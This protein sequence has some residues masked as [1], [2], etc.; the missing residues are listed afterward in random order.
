MKNRFNKG[1]EETKQNKVPKY[2]IR[3][4]KVG[5]VSCLLAFSMFAPAI[6]AQAEL[7]AARRVHVKIDEYKNKG[8]SDKLFDDVNNELKNAA[9]EITVLLEQ[10][11]QNEVNI[12]K[13]QEKVKEAQS[14]EDGA[15]KALK[16][17][18]ATYEQRRKD[19]DF[20]VADLKEKKKAARN[21]ERAYNKAK[22]R[23]EEKSKAYDRLKSNEDNIGKHL[24]DVTIPAKKKALDE[25][26]KKLHD[27]QE[28]LNK[29]SAAKALTE[30]DKEIKDAVARDASVIAA[31]NK[32][33]DLGKETPGLVI[34]YSDAKTN[35]DKAV[36]DTATAVETALTKVN[37]F[38][39]TGNLTTVGDD[40]GKKVLSVL[41]QGTKK[42]TPAAK[43]KAKL[44]YGTVKNTDDADVY[45]AQADVQNKLVEVTNLEDAQKS[46]VVADTESGKEGEAKFTAGTMKGATDANTY[47]EKVN[48][49]KDAITKFNNALQTYNSTPAP[50]QKDNAADY[51]K[52]KTDLKNAIDSYNVAV[53]NAKTNA[54]ADADKKKAEEIEKAKVKLAEAKKKAAETIIAKKVK[55]AEEAAKGIDLDDLTK[56]AESAQKDLLDAQATVDVSEMTQDTYNKR[57]ERA[58]KNR[59]EA[60]AKFD[61]ADKANELAT[62]SR[63][64]SQIKKDDAEQYKNE[65]EKDKDAA[66]VEKNDAHEAL[67]MWKESLRLTKLYAKVA[68]NGGKFK[69]TDGSTTVLTGI[70]PQ[71]KAIVSAAQT[72]YDLVKDDL[73]QT[74]KRVELLKGLVASVSKFSGMSGDTNATEAFSDRLESYNSKLETL[75]DLVADKKE[76]MAE[77]TALLEIVK[78]LSGEADKQ[79]VRNWGTEGWT[80]EGDGWSYTRKDGT[81]ARDEWIQ[82]KFGDW[83][84]VQG[85]GKMAQNQWFQVKGK[86]FFAGANGVLAQNQWLQ[87]KQGDWF[88]VKNG[89]Y[90]AQNEWVQVKGVWYYAQGNGA[91]AKNVT[92]NI[93]GVS[94][95]FNG[96]CAWVK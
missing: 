2:G 84:Y 25:A 26:V 39:E 35:S 59:D 12:D 43:A 17:A 40:E 48:A 60:E 10:I 65:A 46:S 19:Y 5:V 87:N 29:L 64:A 89:G 50:A 23:L 72:K 71:I 7:P 37:G 21:T 92:L 70:K 27:S 81:T 79:T 78:K 20:A 30:D 77:T 80:Q 47:N 31:Q 38:E 13:A 93:N 88:Y 74:E 52:A 8:D 36:K 73:E 86:W 6:G 3:K 53:K 14:R 22:A 66:R 91:L 95:S 57:L 41:N 68:I 83:F 54:K 9:N 62:D 94:Y 67:R 56:K 90:M 96:N 33:D 49:L 76:R 44:T 11:Q 63:D 34:K 42:A 82:N 69:N 75:L 4:L 16:D 85:S 18:I 24:T 32:V 58:E 55:D 45:A 61:E 51:K 28:L 1:F 15:T